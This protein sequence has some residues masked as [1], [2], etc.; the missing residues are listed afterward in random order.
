MKIKNRLIAATFLAGTA[1]LTSPVVL[2]EDAGWYAGGSLGSARTDSG[3]TAAQLDA[4]L[5][6]LTPSITAR[7]TLSENDIGYKLF[8][9]YQFNKNLAVEGGYVDLGKPIEL[10]SVV[11]APSAGTLKG[12][13]KNNGLNLDVLGIL[14]INDAFS[15]FAKVGLYYSKT[16]FD[17]SA[18]GGGGT[19]AGSWSKSEIN[20]KFGLG[21]N[22]AFTKNVGVRAEW[23]RYKNLGDADTTGEG[24]VDLWSIGA[25]FKF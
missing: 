2:A 1:T 9:G 10:N 24:D 8:V 17:I 20:P 3:I 7:S 22:Y 12:T 25:T 11:T 5:A 23:E 14:P 4:D 19:A 15:A 13:I 18:T 16:T 6:A 21:A